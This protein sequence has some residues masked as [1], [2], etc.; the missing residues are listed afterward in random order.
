M[1]SIWNQFSQICEKVEKEEKR[2]LERGETLVV[3]LFLAFG[4]A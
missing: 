4:Y 1:A 2:E 3:V